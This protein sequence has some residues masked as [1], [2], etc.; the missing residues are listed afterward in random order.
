MNEYPEAHPHAGEMK[1]LRAKA[2][3]LYREVEDAENNA[4]EAYK[5]SMD[6]LVYMGQQRLLTHEKLKAIAEILKEI[7]ELASKPFI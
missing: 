2:D 1:D 3:V 6:Q 7:E 4:R 5:Q